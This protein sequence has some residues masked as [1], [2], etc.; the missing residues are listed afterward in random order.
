MALTMG[1]SLARSRLGNRTTD[2][3]LFF[4]KGTLAGLVKLHFEAMG[5]ISASDQSHTCS[6]LPN[7]DLA[8]TSQSRNH[9]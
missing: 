8:I 1:S 9:D 5:K 6:Y 2:Q 4:E 7:L 3:V